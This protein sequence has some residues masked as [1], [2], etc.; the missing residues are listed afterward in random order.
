M[1]FVSDF[2]ALDVQG[3]AE[4]TTEAI[5]KKAPWSVFKLHSTSVTPELLERN[6]DK[7]WIF[8]N[9]SQV[10]TE[11]ILMVPELAGLK[12]SV[13]EYDFKFCRHRSA[14]K[15]FLDT[16]K[17]CDCATSDHGKF[18]ERF[19]TGAQ[20]MFWMSGRQREEFLKHVPG[21]ASANSVVQGSVFDD[22]TL[23]T[24]GRLRNTAKNNKWAILSGGSWI[25]GVEQTEAWCKFQKKDYYKIP[26]KA[27]PDFLMDLSRHR[28]LVFMPLD[29]DTCP[30]VTIE[31]K[32]MGC[33]L[34]LNDNVLQKD[35][36][37]FLGSPAEVYFHLE[38][39][40]RTFWNSITLTT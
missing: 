12:Y 14:Y 25:K 18:I 7:Y 21:V 40:A 26:A 13:I 31:A 22:D 29:H 19:Y 6:R 39:R 30:R 8:G 28:G 1:V 27:Y 24:L 17:V 36:S 38:H 37:W 11:T 23:S 9:F 5:I 33:E 15:H 34:I 16:G 35:E 10:P 2:F 4:L 32:L 20:T 3:G